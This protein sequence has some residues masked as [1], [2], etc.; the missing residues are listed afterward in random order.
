MSDAREV[1]RRIERRELADWRAEYARLLPPV[2][3]PTRT[4][5]CTC[6]WVEEKLLCATEPELVHTHYGEDCPDHEPP[7]KVP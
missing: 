1:I 7:E 2:S 6:A 3:A 5:R 4:P